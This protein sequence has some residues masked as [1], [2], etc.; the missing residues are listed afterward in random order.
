MLK[1]PSCGAALL[2]S[3]RRWKIS[4]HCCQGLSVLLIK[5]IRIHQGWRGGSDWTMKT[6]CEVF[7]FSRI[8][9]KKN[10]KIVSFYP[11]L[12][13][14]QHGNEGDVFSLQTEFCRNITSRLDVF[15]HVC[16]LT[17]CFDWEFC[18]NWLLSCGLMSGQTLPISWIRCGCWDYMYNYV[19]LSYEPF[20]VN[21]KVKKYVGSWLLLCIVSLTNVLF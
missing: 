18:N 16:C 14:Q 13:T 3:W 8:L 15:V 20:L 6:W 19:Y 7:C 12:I 1:H 10:K 11:A 4:S 2:T 17:A 21:Y 5:M 9:T